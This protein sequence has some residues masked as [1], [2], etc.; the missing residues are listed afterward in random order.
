MN[1]RSVLVELI[2]LDVVCWYNVL[3]RQ[4]S[5]SNGSRL[6]RF[7]K[8]EALVLATGVKAF[9]WSWYFVIYAK[10]VLLANWSLIFRKVDM[11]FSTLVKPSLLPMSRSEWWNALILLS[12][13]ITF[14]EHALSYSS[15]IVVVSIAIK[16]RWC[17]QTTI[18]LKLIIVFYWNGVIVVALTGHVIT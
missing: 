12:V 7:S 15:G 10:P 4:T 16:T 13:N 1:D 14:L 3:W 9:N 8:P 18:G 11:I 5:S 17:F 2:S 6:P